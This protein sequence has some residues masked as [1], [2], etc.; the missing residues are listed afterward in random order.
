M[1]RLTIVF[2]V[3]ALGFAFLGFRD[4][5]PGVLSILAIAIFVVLTLAGLICLN[6]AILRKPA[7]P[8]RPEPPTAHN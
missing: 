7:E 6:T 4:I 3:L 2:L 1:I 5:L 8:A